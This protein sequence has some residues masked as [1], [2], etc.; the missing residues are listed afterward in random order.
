MWK[1]DA[2]TFDH[3]FTLDY[4]SLVNGTFMYKQD[5]VVTPDSNEP[6]F[7]GDYTGL[8]YLRACSSTSYLDAETQLCVP[9]ELNK[10]T[11]DWLANEC[12]SAA[13][14]WESCTD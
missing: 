6:S 12:V 4:V 8:Q 9:C 10:G 1:E 7:E 13:V 2:L 11:T 5:L 3:D 14:M